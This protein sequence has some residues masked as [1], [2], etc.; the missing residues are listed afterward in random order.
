MSEKVGDNHCQPC[1][2]QEP[3]LRVREKLVMT[4][5]IA[6]VHASLHPG[7]GGDASSL[8]T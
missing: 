6:Y 2:G 8:T 1:C 4:T 5:G 7:M 3:T